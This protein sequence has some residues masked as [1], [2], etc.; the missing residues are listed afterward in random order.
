MPTWVGSE[1]WQQ[2]SR[3]Q[4]SI[5]KTLTHLLL[6]GTAGTKVVQPESRLARTRLMTTRR[7][8]RRTRTRA[9]CPFPSP[10]WLL[11]W[12]VEG[13]LWCLLWSGSE[14]T[15]WDFFEWPLTSP[16][17]CERH[18]IAEMLACNLLFGTSEINILCYISIPLILHQILILCSTT[19]HKPC[20]RFLIPWK[21]PGSK[22]PIQ[23]KDDIYESL[24]WF[25]QKAQKQIML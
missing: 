21:P 22:S 19:R 10:T 5:F 8:R 4:T 23:Q 7:A 15:G 9:R 12:S 13:L 3:G 6:P 11:G 24:C 20:K 18:P 17:S 1:P 16:N 2:V 14:K 25:H